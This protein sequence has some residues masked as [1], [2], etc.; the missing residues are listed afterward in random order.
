MKQIKKEGFLPQ[1]ALLLK[2]KGMDMKNE[3]TIAFKQSIYRNSRCR[4]YL[5]RGHDSKTVMQS[6]ENVKLHTICLIVW[7]NN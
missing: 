3:K 6:Y 5:S 7:R 4:E 1:D 2:I